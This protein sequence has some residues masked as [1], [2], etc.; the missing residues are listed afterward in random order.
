MKNI[1]NLLL[2]GFILLLAFDSRIYTDVMAIV[3]RIIHFLLLFYLLWILLHDYLKSFK[4]KMGEK[5]GLQLKI[6][7]RKL[8]KIKH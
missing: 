4:K 5:F 7:K 3:I 8:F 6:I 1:G 2:A